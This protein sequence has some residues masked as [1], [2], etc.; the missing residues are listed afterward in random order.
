MSKRKHS[1]EGGIVKET[2]KER[3]FFA[4]FLPHRPDNAKSGGSLRNRQRTEL[5]CV[6][7][8]ASSCRRSPEAAALPL[9]G[10]FVF[11]YDLCVLFVP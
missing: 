2:V 6:F 1:A 8:S 3:N 7:P 9:P 11:F 10:G 5:F 4:L